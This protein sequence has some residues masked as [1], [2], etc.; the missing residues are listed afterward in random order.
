MISII[1]CHRNK[2]FLDGITKSI[3]STIGVPYEL[4]IIDNSENKY[5]ILSAYNTG[6]KRANFD[7][8]CFSH[9]DI[10]FYTQNWGEKVIAHFKN[11]EVGMIGIMGALAQSAVPSAWWFNNYF[12]KTVRNFLMRSPYTKDKK[13]YRYYSNPYNDVD[14][15]EVVIIDGLWF[16]IRKDLFKKIEFD[17]KVFKGFHLYDADISMQVLQYA[18]NYVIFDILLDH[19][20]TGKISG[21]Y[22]MDLIR[23]ANKW[24]DKLPVQNH[25]IE[26]RYMDTYNWHAL[27]TLILEIKTKDIPDKYIRDIFKKYY[28]ILISQHNSY[29]FRSYFFLSRF[30]GFRY[31]NSVFYRIEKLAGICKTPGYVRKE[32]IEN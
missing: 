3:K 32:F 8:L 4:I 7:I 18:K 5:N 10:V 12:A 13:M 9:E 22:Y 29:W 20:W 26:N 6:V 21:D 1:I 28:S 23:F 31:A 27:R 17:E 16:C 30:I 24:K 15:T 25:K 2:N 14:K 19:F 11:P